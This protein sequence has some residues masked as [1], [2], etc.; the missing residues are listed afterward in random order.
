[1]CACTHEHGVNGKILLLPP[2]PL[3]RVGSWSWRQNYVLL[4]PPPSTESRRLL[5][6]T[7]KTQEIQQALLGSSGNC[8]IMS[9]RASKFNRHVWRNFGDNTRCVRHLN[10]TIESKY[11]SLIISFPGAKVNASSAFR[12]PT[13][14]Y[15]HEPIPLQ[16]CLGA[17]QRICIPKINMHTIFQIKIIIDKLRQQFN[18]SLI[19][20]T[21]S[22]NK[23]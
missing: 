8:L 13:R 22:Y 6:I 3:N 16:Q 23:R 14:L 11:Y 12:K 9:V 5:E 19:I 10:V 15:E 21:T 18:P 7:E 4:P 20:G 2:P 1:M 17:L